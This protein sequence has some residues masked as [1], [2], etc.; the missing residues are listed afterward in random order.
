MTNS[1]R[2]RESNNSCVREWRRLK[3]CANN[4]SLT[5]WKYISQERKIIRK[6]I[7]WANKGV[8][9]LSWVLFQ[10]CLFRVTIPI[11]SDARLLAYNDRGKGRKKRSSQMK[12]EWMNTA[13]SNDRSSVFSAVLLSLLVCE[14]VTLMTQTIL[15]FNPSC[16]S[17]LKH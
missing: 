2:H 5:Q 7:K 16:R 3:N 12:K 6:G 15:F 13:P 11:T 17:D 1:G 9:H 4:Y 14:C 8:F 10:V